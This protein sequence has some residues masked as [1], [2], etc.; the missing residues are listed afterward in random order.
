[1]LIHAIFIRSDSELTREIICACAKLFVDDE[2]VHMAQID[3]K[4]NNTSYMTCLC[5]IYA[6]STSPQTG[7][8]TINE[9]EFI[10]IHEIL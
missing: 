10:Y 4:Y 1:M 8:P 3:V 2:N 5:Y 6:W 9:K 7:K